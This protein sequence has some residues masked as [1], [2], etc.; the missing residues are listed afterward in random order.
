M[1]L[2]LQEVRVHIK[3]AEVGSLVLGQSTDRYKLA[4]LRLVLVSKA[5]A[6]FDLLANTRKSYQASKGTISLVGS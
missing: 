4:H 2:A 3:F 1:R 6:I 5:A